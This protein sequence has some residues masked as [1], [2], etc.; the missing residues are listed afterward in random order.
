MW[1][2]VVFLATGDGEMMRRSD[3]AKSPQ[4]DRVDKCHGQTDRV[5]RIITWPFVEGPVDDVIDRAAKCQGF[6]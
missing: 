4:S 2:V 3:C 6:E 1:G 5:A